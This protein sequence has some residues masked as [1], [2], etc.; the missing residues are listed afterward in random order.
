MENSRRKIKLTIIS[1][2]HELCRERFEPS[3]VLISI[4]D[5]EPYLASFLAARGIPFVSLHCKLRAADLAR[6]LWK[7]FRYCRRERPD[8][9]HTHILFASLLGLVGAALARVPVRIVTRHHVK[10]DHVVPGHG[11]ALVWLDR[12][13]NLLASRVIATCSMLRQV[14]VESEKIPAGKVRLVHLGIDLEKF[15]RPKAAEVAA[16]ARRY[17]PRGAAPVI[18]VVARHFEFKGIQ[19][20]IPAFRRLLELYPTAYLLMAGA[21]GPYHE[22][23]RRQLAPIAPERYV[24]VTFE[25]NPFALYH[26]CDLVVHAPIGPHEESFGLVYLEALAAGVPSIF[27]LA[28]VAPEL[29]EHGRNAWI[30][31]PRNSEQI[32][33]GMVALLRDAALRRRL[34]RA[35]LRSLDPA[36]SARVMQR[37]VEAVYLECLRERPPDR[38]AP[39][40]FT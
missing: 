11:K 21:Y 12:L 8:V 4:P 20:V 31:E 36:W 17:N 5:T 22:A 33:Q 35:G 27:S 32:Y 6:T 23:L 26:L 15:R 34:V 40:L 39:I 18:G 30:V 38:L 2:F 14:L 16:L 29:L 28:G 19:Y 9:V 1:G 7:I 10:L 13:S 3:F 37:A 24:L 25:P